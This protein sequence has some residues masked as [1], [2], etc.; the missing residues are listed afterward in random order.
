M[1]LRHALPWMLVIV[2]SVAIYGTAHV[3]GGKQKELAALEQKIAAEMETVHVLRAE[4]SFLSHPARLEELA[5]R[6]T[7][8]RPTAIAQFVEVDGLPAVPGLP[9]LRGARQ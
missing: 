7:G 4:L 5:T 3:V 1:M 9:L 2:L 8:M 6:H